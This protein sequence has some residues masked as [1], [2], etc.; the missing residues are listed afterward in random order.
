MIMDGSWL[1]V[2]FA[3]LMAI[4]MVMY[5][6]LDGYD[7]GVG[8]LMS[9]AEAQ[10][11]DRMIASIGPFWD[12]NETWLV[13]GTGLLLV[14]FPLANGMILSA[15][16]IPVSVMLL[17]LIL[18]GVAY[19]FRAKVHARH[20][21][22]WNRCFIGGS[23]V[24]SISQGCMLG[25]YI[26]GFEADVS[27]WLFAVLCGLGLSSAY[28]LIG[29][30]WLIMKAEGALQRH[31]VRWARVALWFS[32]GAIGL[33]SI[34]TP[35]MI[36]M[37]A[38]K[39]F[40]MPNLILLLPIPGMTAL[41]IVLIDRLLVRLPHAE[42]RYCSLPFILVMGVFLLCFCGLAFSFYPYIVPGQLTIFDSASAPESLMIILIGA[43][44]VLPFIFAY[45]VYA[46]RVF[47]GKLQ[48]LDY[49]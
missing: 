22:L 15:L 26:T 14:A 9:L 19:D 20:K 33:V 29:A 44:M 41:L 7:L 34:A 10:D 13:L 23:V 43:V 42:D 17:G 45:T 16:Y 48:S 25:M 31:A 5:V 35:M 27:G 21:R 36:P 11:Q 39:W 12:A 4:S 37:V 6:I 40:S 2:V 46:Y 1:I 32:A 38:E 8:L 24:A 47:K 28:V 3:G 18:R 30:C 49:G